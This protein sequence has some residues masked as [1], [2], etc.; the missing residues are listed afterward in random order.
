M[1][2]YSSFPNIVNYERSQID[3]ISVFKRYALMYENVIFNRYGCPI[4]NL[5]CNSLSEFIAFFAIEKNE[6]GSDTLHR[7]SS[8][9]KNKKFSGIF[10]DLWDV[11]ENPEQADKDA[12][13]YLSEKKRQEIDTFSVNRNKRDLELGIEN[14][15]AEYKAPAIVSSDLC[16]ELYYNF[17]LADLFDDFSINLSPVV[18][19]LIDDMKQQ[20]N[21]NSLFT[22]SLIIPDFSKLSWDQILE[23][24]TDRHI[25]DFRTKVLSNLNKNEPIDLALANELQKDLWDL[26]NYCKPDIKKSI[27]EFVLSNMPIPAPLNPFGLYYSVRDMSK[28]YKNQD[29][30]WIYFVQKLNSKS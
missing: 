30:N 18:S 21:I 15:H 8:L 28:E 29:K 2:A 23:L 22:S 27:F 17:Y 16:S 1:K 6:N 5:F 20:Q 3:L 24:R 26:A 14:H 10:I 4:N 13:L 7:A 11:V 12:K 25:H 9:G 19:D